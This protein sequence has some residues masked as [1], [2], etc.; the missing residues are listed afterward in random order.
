VGQVCT[1]CVMDRSDPD[2]S[3]GSDGVCSH[4]ARAAT[5][6]PTVHWTSKASEQALA[7]LAGT[8]RRASVGH[9]YDCVIGLSGGVDSSYTALIAN[10]LGLR[11]L[12]VHFDNGWNTELAVENI[13]RVVDGCGFDLQTYVINWREFRDLQRAFLLASVVDIELLTDHAI[14][15]AMVGL[16]R[17]HGIRYVLSGANIATE[18]GLPRAWVWNKLDWRNI[19][20]IHATYGTVPLKSFPHLTAGRWAAMRLRRQLTVLEPLNLTNYRRDEASAT[21]AKEFGWRDYG[22]KHHE[23]AFTKFY[24][25]VILP[26]K[27]GIDKRRVHLSDAVR[28]GE[29]SRDEAMRILATPPYEPDELRQDSE[30]VRKKLGFSEPEWSAILAARPRSHSEFAS[31]AVRM[32]QVGSLVR[33]ARKLVRPFRRKQLA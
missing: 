12:A 14:F 25:G 7:D 4:C 22:G 9:E 13:Q 10:R 23:S 3:F 26:E 33:L 18:H 6:L 1:R 2:I 17:T 20:A 8:V 28:N 15:A 30:Y 29:M 11:P 31:D 19:Q 16:A 24:Q 21:L 5:L 27:F 32:A